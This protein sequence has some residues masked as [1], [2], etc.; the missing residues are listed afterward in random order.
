MLSPIATVVESI[1]VVVP[2]TSRLPFITTVD[3]LSVIREF[4]K[5]PSASFH[6]NNVLSVKLL[7]FLM[8]KLAAPLDAPP[9]KPEPEFVFTAVISPAPVPAPIAALKSLALKAVVVLLALNLGNLTALGFVSPNT[10][11]PISVAPKLLKALPA[12]V[13]PVPPFEIG[14]VSDKVEP[15]AVIVISALPLKFT[16]LIALAVWRIVADAALPLVL[17][18]PAALTPGKFMF[19]EPLK[20]TPPI[21]L[22]VSRVVAVSALPVTSPVKAP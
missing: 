19:A 10:D 11:L 6:T 9:D 4:S 5:L 8:I 22:A 15:A 18:L 3:P 13:A 12:L 20:L 7:T 16:P 1:V 21:V 2:W 14:T 17:W